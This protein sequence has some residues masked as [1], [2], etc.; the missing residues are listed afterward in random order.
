MKDKAYEEFKKDFIN[1]FSIKREDNGRTIINAYFKKS[2]DFNIA[3]VNIENKNYLIT[4]VDDAAKA[5]VGV[6]GL[7][8][9]GLILE[10]LNEEYFEKAH[11]EYKEQTQGGTND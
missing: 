1:Q 2:D 5:K 11:E 10:E 4:L 7:S 8:L 3:I 9:T 6:E